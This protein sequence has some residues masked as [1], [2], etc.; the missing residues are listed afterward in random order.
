MIP[1][2]EQCLELLRSHNV[3]RNIITHSLI[4]SRVAVFL[5]KE[6]NKKGF[7]LN[8]NEIEAA[9]LLHDIKKIDSLRSGTG[10]AHDAWLLLRKLG[11]NEVAEIV[12]QH[13]FLDQ[14]NDSSKIK[15]EEVVNYSDKRV[16]HS[17]IVTLKERFQYLKERYGKDEESI[18]VINNLER[19]AFEIENKIFSNIDFKP[20]EIPKLL[21]MRG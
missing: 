14:N 8:I 13:V 3:P 6:L 5:A 15:E 16:R 11:Y 7:N 17:D 2:R 20:E 19:K 9:A 1:S 18:K 21:R 4:V 12:K 10:H